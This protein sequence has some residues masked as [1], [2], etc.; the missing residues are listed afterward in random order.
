[1]IIHPIEPVFNNESE[2][3]ILGSFPSVK[4]REA[5]F[6]YGHPQNR[7]WK[8]IA[9]LYDEEIPT[10]IEEKKALLLKNHLAVWDV[11]AQC[12]IEGSSDS[13][14]KN[15]VANDLSV[16]LDNAQIKAIY[17]NGKTAEKYYKKYIE[18]TIGRKAICLPSTSPANAMWSFDRLLEEWR[19]I[20]D[21]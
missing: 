7:F 13:S 20:L 21:N 8:V 1:M 5:M 16:I 11:I 10:N 19:V 17:V 14:I 18:K 2:V 15:V 3:L 6:F 4:S 9:S 12:D